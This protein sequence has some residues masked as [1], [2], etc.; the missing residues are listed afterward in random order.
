[1]THPQVLHDDSTRFFEVKFFFRATV[2]GTQESLAL[3]S[4]YSFVDEDLRAYSHSAL[5]VFGYRGE[6]C[7]VVIKVNSIIS[8]VAMVPFEQDEG[9]C[10][11][12]LIEKCAL[13]VID[14]EDMLDL[15]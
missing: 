15:E 3:G 8:A 7:L 9:G 12:Y 4:L 5:N 11:F 14:S 10:R 1:M 13:G 2:A 6:E